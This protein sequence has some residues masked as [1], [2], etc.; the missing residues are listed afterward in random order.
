[1]NKKYER[2]ITKTANDRSTNEDIS[3]QSGKIHDASNKITGKSKAEH[4]CPLSNF[5]Q[6][7]QVAIHVHAILIIECS[8]QSR[9]FPCVHELAVLAH[10]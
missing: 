7:Q 6:G 8:L 9:R 3:T 5:S 2:L 1:M 10:D 4:R